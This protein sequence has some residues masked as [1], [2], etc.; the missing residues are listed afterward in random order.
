MLADTID[1]L[2]GSLLVSLIALSNPLCRYLQS[3]LPICKEQVA[4]LK[5]KA[6]TCNLTNRNLYASN[7]SEILLYTNLGKHPFLS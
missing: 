3:A 7:N 1:G 2:A 6:L 4:V 5:T